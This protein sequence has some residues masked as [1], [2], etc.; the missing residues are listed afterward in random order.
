MNDVQRLVPSGG[1]LRNEAIYIEMEIC[2]IRLTNFY[3]LKTSNEFNFCFSAKRSIHFHEQTNWSLRDNAK[4][5][6]YRLYTN[7]ENET[8]KPTAT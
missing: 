5:S 2:A 7:G 1:S 6:D 4:I 8:N 3:V